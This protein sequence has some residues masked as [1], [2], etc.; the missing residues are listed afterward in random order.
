MGNPRHYLR[1]SRLALMATVGM[2]LVMEGGSISASAATGRGRMAEMRRKGC[3]CV[4]LPAGG[5]CCEPATRSKAVVS[6]AASQSSIELRVTAIAPAGLSLP[7]SSC[8][9]R[10]YDPVAPAGQDEPRPEQWRSD[11]VA[12]NVAG[13]LAFVQ[14]VP[15]PSIPTVTPTRLPRSPLYIRTA[16]LLI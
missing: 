7:Q 10:A 16:R 15:A 9:C 14:I 11:S 1:F 6:P 2:L 8:Q 5:C 12:E 3:C 13:L 4:T